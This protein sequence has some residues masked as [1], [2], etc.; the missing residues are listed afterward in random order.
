M[1]TNWCHLTMAAK[2]YNTNCKLSLLPNY[3]LC[4]LPRFIETL[5]QRL[6]KSPKDSLVAKNES[7]CPTLQWVHRCGL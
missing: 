2:L 3:L 4:T 7:P 6:D 5:D 1:V